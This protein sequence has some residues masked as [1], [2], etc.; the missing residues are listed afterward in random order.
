MLLGEEHSLGEDEPHCMMERG[1]GH[2]RT[3]DEYDQEMV[4]K[5]TWHCVESEVGCLGLGCYT[6][7]WCWELAEDDQ[8]A[9]EVGS[10]HQVAKDS[11]VV[12]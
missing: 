5:A 1:D 7:S 3:E 6:D 4:N 9:S 11:V 2:L 12:M 8:E 10:V